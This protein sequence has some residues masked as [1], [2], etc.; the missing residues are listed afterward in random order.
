MFA[1]KYRNVIKK[2]LTLSLTV[3]YYLKGDCE[4]SVDVGTLNGSIS[5]PDKAL[6]PELSSV[7]MTV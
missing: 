6:N 7:G 1:K 4:F 5:S 2:P 3:F